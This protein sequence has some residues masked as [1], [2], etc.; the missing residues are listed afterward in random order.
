MENS[1]RSLF[2]LTEFIV[3]V[4]ELYGMGLSSPVSS[5]S[6]SESDLEP[7]I[8]ESDVVPRL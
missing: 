8:P 7:D 3:S 2:D 1:P 6:V 4:L 5:Q